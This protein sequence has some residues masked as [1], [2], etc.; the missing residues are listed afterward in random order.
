MY[1]I[2][3]AFWLLISQKNN[4]VPPIECKQMPVFIRKTG[5]DLSRSGFSTAERKQKGLVF[6]EFAADGDAK[7][8]RFYQPESWKKAGSMGPIIID[9][10]GIVFAA[11]VPTVNILDNPIALQNTLYKVDAQSGEMS[12][13]IALPDSATS[14]Y[15]KQ[16]EQNPF[17]L[18]GLAYDC[19]TKLLYATSVKG[20]TSDAEAGC[21]WIINKSDKKI[22]ASISKIDAM[23]IGIYTK[24]GEKRVYLGKTRTGDII[25]Y[26]LN[27]EGTILKNTEQVEV[28]LEGLG[29]RGDDHARKIRFNEK[30][31]MVVQGISFY[32]N[33]V[34]PSEKQETTYI[35]RYNTATQRWVFVRYGA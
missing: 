6:V 11:P 33:L 20:S 12:A 18:L 32:Y 21:V 19:G 8:N 17:G 35:F 15:T 16:P 3:L 23:G 4:T 9:E 14:E 26:Q 29:G 34:A 28:S 2:F 24:N 1:S 25:S 7:K 10:E 31:E 22:T 27:P 13:F 30:N 5:F